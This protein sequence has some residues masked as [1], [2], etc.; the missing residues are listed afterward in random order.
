M[1]SFKSWQNVRLLD[2]N[3]KISHGDYILDDMTV[4]ITDGFLNDVV[5]HIG[6]VVEILP[7]IEAFDGSHIEH[8]QN[9]V[10]H[11]AGAPAVIDKEDDYEEWWL[12]G[13][14]VTPEEAKGYIAR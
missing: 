4:R 13:K 9:G 8:W 5:S 3:K 6:G 1:K 10:L 2:D 12:H 11:K 7:A 14:K